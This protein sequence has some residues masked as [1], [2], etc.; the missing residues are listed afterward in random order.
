MT[1]LEGIRYK[2]SNG[3]AI[4]ALAMLFIFGP[5]I[6]YTLFKKIGIFSED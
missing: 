1:Q 2:T 6:G 5:I 4:T 3:I